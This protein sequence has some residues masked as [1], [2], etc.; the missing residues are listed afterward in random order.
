MKTKNLLFFV[1]MFMT[2]SLLPSCY[3]IIHENRVIWETDVLKAERA[4][5]PFRIQY[6]QNS[7]I[8]VSNISIDTLVMTYATDASTIPD[9]G[10]MK[11]IWE[12]KNKKWIGDEYSFLFDEN[13]DIDRKEI[14]VEIEECSIYKGKTKYVA[15]WP[16][17]LLNK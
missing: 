9:W 4:K 10:Y 7:G 15:K 11:T 2:L 5:L 16:E 17:N 13:Y 6:Y 12:L 3:K 8:D 1:I 14:L